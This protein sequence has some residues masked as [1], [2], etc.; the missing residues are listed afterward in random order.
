VA[1]LQLDFL[2]RDLGP[3]PS[4]ADGARN[5]TFSPKWDDHRPFSFAEYGFRI[6]K[7]RMIGIMRTIPKQDSGQPLL[8]EEWTVR[9]PMRQDRNRSSMLRGS[10]R[11]LFVAA[12]HAVAFRSFSFFVQAQTTAPAPKA[13]NA[14][15]ENGTFEWLFLL[16]DTGKEQGIWTKNG[17]APRWVPAAASA[18]QLREQ[19]ASGTKIGFVNTAEVLLAR[20]NGLPV[21]VVAGYFGPTIAKIFAR[22]EGPLKTPKDL[23]GKK[24]GI[25]SLSHTSYRTVLYLNSTLGIKSEPVPVG[26]LANNLA[27]LKEGKIDAFYSSE[28]AALS[29]VD[30]GELRMLT[31]LSEL[32]PKPYTAVV[33]WATDDLIALDPDLV[34]RFVRA[35]LETVGYLQADPGRASELYVKRTHAPK[36]L[37]DRTVA[38]LNRHLTVTGAGSGEDLVTAVAGSWQFTQQSGAVAAGTTVKVE[39]AVD[40][41]FLPRR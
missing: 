9:T 34:T 17:L 7:L 36:N 15:G 11:L 27:A 8:A 24:I 32:Y 2:E 22:A 19:V 23:D 28:G 39:E 12:V 25:L 18:T 16:T 35:T 20:S 14:A 38:E 31:R 4:N 5:D 41:R 37:A 30:S 10:M 21:K 1:G 6:A 3:A 33:V 29:L 40:N 26:N 13:F